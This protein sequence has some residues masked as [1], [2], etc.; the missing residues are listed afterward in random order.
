M[1]LGLASRDFERSRRDEREVHRPS[2]RVGAEEAAGDPREGSRSV[3]SC[4]VASRE[5]A[6][7]GCG[8]GA[9]DA[10]GAAAQR[11]CEFPAFRCDCGVGP[12]RPVKRPSTIFQSFPGAVAFSE[13]RRAQRYLDRFRGAS[14]AG[15]FAF[16]FRVRAF[17]GGEARFE[18]AIG[19]CDFYFRSRSQHRSAGVE[20]GRGGRAYRD[21]RTQSSYSSNR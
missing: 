7:V 21:N 10:A 5:R 1:S 12:T 3:Q 16:E 20:S 9:V 11:H 6:Y 14:C 18:H 4:R 8:R 2:R 13:D 17:E 15:G 19:A